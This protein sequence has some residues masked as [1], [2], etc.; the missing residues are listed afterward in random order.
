MHPTPRILAAA[1]VAVLA[2]PAAVAAKPP[3][4]FN[5]VLS[6]DTVIGGI[7]ACTTQ[8]VP[9]PV[10]KRVLVDAVQVGFNSSLRLS[11]APRASIGLTSKNGA[12]ASTSVEL[13]IPL[14]SETGFG[15][16]SGRRMLGIIATGNALEAA[17]VGDVF[18]MR[19]CLNRGT[20]AS[21]TAT[22]LITG[23]Y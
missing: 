2:V 19:M 16:A 3:K 15:G 4:P 13:S 9:L 7:G 10:G 6:F 23:H 8:T 1:L 5:A 14:D 17:A 18:F 20:A 12:G 22:V 11:D 21:A